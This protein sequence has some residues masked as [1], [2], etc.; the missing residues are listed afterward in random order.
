MGSRRHLRRIGQ[1]H[2]PQQTTDVKTQLAKY[3]LQQPI[4]LEA[5]TA[6]TAVNQLLFQRPIVKMDLSGQQNIQI[7]KRDR[8]IVVNMQFAQGVKRYIRGSRPAQTRKI[9]A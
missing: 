7:F 6:T 5:V 8:A 9:S 4:L 2:A 1:H 3:P